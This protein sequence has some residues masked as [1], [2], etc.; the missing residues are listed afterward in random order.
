MN[1]I[2]SADIHDAIKLTERNSL[3]LLSY[4]MRKTY[5]DHM[6]S[7]TKFAVTRPGLIAAPTP[8]KVASAAGSRDLGFISRQER[9]Q[10][11]HFG[12]IFGFDLHGRAL[13][14]KSK[15]AASQPLIVPQDEAEALIVDQSDRGPE[16][17]PVLIQRIV[18]NYGQAQGPAIRFEKSGDIDFI[19]HGHRLT[20]RLDRGNLRSGRREEHEQADAPQ[21]SHNGNKVHEHPDQGHLHWRLKWYQRP[22][23]ACVTRTHT[24]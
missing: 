14:I 24:R 2:R 10:D 21:G 4:K 1:A 7:L 23:L 22:P 17:S 15:A 3:P 12:I 19:V 13:A 5:T 20:R 11:I 18:K 9:S 6:K 16:Q 8:M